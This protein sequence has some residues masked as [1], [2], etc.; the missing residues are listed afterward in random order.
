MCNSGLGFRVQGLGF[1]VLGFRVEASG[2]T[3]SGR[4][5][6]AGRWKSMGCTWRCWLDL[7]FGAQDLGFGV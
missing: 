7:G 2:G 3:Q 6:P 1:R 4:C 5:R